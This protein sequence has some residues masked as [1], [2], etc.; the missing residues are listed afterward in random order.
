MKTNCLVSPNFEHL[1]HL[2]G[3]HTRN[4]GGANQTET[5]FDHSMYT[6]LSKCFVG[7]TR[8]SQLGRKKVIFRPPASLNLML[9]RDWSSTPPT[10]KNVK[11]YQETL[12]K[13]IE[14]Y[15]KL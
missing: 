11:R 5:A 15:E 2:P 1:Q 10:T 8:G 12:T 4:S 7:R 13:N 9:P 3:Y 14:L 6:P